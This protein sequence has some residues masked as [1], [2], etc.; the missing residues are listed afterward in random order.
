MNQVSSSFLGLLSF[1]RVLLSIE[2]ISLE[3]AFIV[4]SHMITFTVDT[5]ERMEVE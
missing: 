3:G 2:V 4:V 1:L 5:L